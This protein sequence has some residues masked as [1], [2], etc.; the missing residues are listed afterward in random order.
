MGNEVEGIRETLYRYCRLLDERQ[1][2]ELVRSVYLPEAVDDR[3]RGAPRRGHDELIAYFEAALVLLEATVHLLSNVEIELHGDTATTRSRVVA[4]H[5]FVGS[6]LF[7]K[8]RP[9]ECVLVGAY[10][11]T[12]VRQADGWRISHRLVRALGPGGLLF[13]QMPEAFRGFGGIH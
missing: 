1:P 8:V 13:G 5:W 3:Q 7:G 12:L 11:D 4:S 2:L 10:E 6:A 9:A